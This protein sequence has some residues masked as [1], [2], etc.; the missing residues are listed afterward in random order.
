MKLQGDKTDAREL[1]AVALA[2]QGVL[3]DVIEAVV[4]VVAERLRLLV[5]EAETARSPSA[6]LDKVPVKVA[7]TVLDSAKGLLEGLHIKLLRRRAAAVG[8]EGEDEQLLVVVRPVQRGDRDAVTPSCTACGQ[9][10]GACQACGDG[11]VLTDQRCRPFAEIDQCTEAH[12]SVCTHCAFWHRPNA[13]R[14]GCESHAV[15]WVILLGVLVVL[16]CFVLAVVLIAGL[17]R[18]FIGF[19]KRQKQERTTCFFKMDRSNV[20]F[21]S[22]GSGLCTSKQT[23]CFED[24]LPLDMKVASGCASATKADASR[25][26]SCSSTVGTLR[27]PRSGSLRR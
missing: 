24:S 13:S 12:D 4:Q 14:T 23:V 11:F 7:L 8:L 15:W 6:E 9:V 1:L 3:L 27:R 5:A 10:D 17:V 2:R 25:R 18:W 26:S 19:K 16:V 21:T 20:R 22:L